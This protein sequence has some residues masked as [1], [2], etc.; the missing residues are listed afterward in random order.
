MHALVVDT[1]VPRRRRRRR[2]RRCRRRRRSVCV[3]VCVCVCACVCARQRA[4]GCARAKDNERKGERESARACARVALALR[5]VSTTRGASGCPPA[6]ARIRRSLA[7]LLCVHQPRVPP[8]CPP[9]RPVLETLDEKR[10]APGC[11]PWGIINIKLQGRQPGAPLFPSKV[12]RT[13][14]LGGAREAPGI[15]PRRGIGGPDARRPA[16]LIDGSPRFQGGQG[17]PMLPL[18]FVSSVGQS[19]GRAGR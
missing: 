13:G 16:L 5:G 8:G 10:G 15:R 18:P 3:C 1:V 2:R 9:R 17:A 19:V 4:R 12:S 6:R 14:R 7:L 11:R